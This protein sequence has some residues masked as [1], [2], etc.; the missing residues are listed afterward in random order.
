MN[1]RQDIDGL[2]ALAVLLVIA[3][4]AF[5]KFMAKGLHGVDIFFVISGFLITSII[6]NSLVKENFSFINF[7]IRRIKR[8]LPM[9]LIVL[10]FVSITGALTLFNAEFERL[11]VH[12]RAAAA[13]YINFQLLKEA[14]YFEISSIYKPLTHYWSL[15]I[16]AQFYLMWPLLLF[17]LFNLFSFAQV[18]LKLKKDRVTH[19]LLLATLSLLIFSLS[20]FWQEKGDQYYSSLIRTWELLLGCFAAIACLE[21]S[22]SSSKKNLLDKLSPQLTLIGIVAIFVGLLVTSRLLGTVL[23]AFGAAFYLLANDDIKIKNFFK[24]KP[25]VLI[26]LMSYSLYL[27]HWPILSF[28]RIHRPHAGFAETILLVTVAFI[29]AYFTYRFIEK[30]L[31]NESWDVKFQADKIRIERFAFIKISICV[32]ASL[33]IFLLGSLGGFAQ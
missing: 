27:W 28:Y 10:F 29:L 23:S 3:F 9:A 1:Y 11:R 33:G 32:I 6:L 31:K 15:A 5:P 17:L 12:I 8:I 20:F 18:R 26:G 25:I 4:H 30:P 2:R 7:Y 16:E 13:F 14:G 21:I 24:I 19:F 22:K